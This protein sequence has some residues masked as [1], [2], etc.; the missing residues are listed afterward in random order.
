MKPIRASERRVLDRRLAG[1]DEA[2]GIR[3]FRGWIRTVRDALG[4]SGFDLATRMGLTQPRVSQLERAEVKGSI[5]LSSLERAAT[6][7]R[8]R[9]CYVFVPEAPL[10]SIVH[11]QARAKAAAELEA[12]D[13]ESGRA[14]GSG[15]EQMG[16]LDELIE[17]RTYELIDAWNLW[18]L[19]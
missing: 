1:L 17:A 18:R 19:T 2:I 3:P 9:L 8:C 10:V 6:A 4:M 5:T 11:G 14:N 7:M 16:E 13:L 15:P 12:A